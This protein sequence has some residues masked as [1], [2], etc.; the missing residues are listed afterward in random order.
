MEAGCMVAGIAQVEFGGGGL[1]HRAS[2]LE[3]TPID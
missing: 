3:D 1:S 2:G